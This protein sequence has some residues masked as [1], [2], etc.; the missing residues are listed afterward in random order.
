MQN[1]SF[2]GRG[3]SFPPQFD[4]RT[5][6]TVMV[7]AEDDI[8]QSLM[9]LFQTRPGE[10]V[11][12]PDFGTDIH[13]LVFAVMNAETMAA[14]E[15]AIRRAVLHFELRISL[16]KVSVDT[17][18]WYEGRFAVT[19]DYTVVET[20]SRANIVYPFYLHEGTLLVDTPTVVL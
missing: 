6:R 8:T 18:D 20:N 2:L 14:I 7:E 10:R 3:W 9:I 13:K 4:S 5:G 16:N 17:Q 12:H 11:L 1:P 15:Q 19:L